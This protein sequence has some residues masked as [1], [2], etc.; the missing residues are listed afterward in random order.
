MRV[1]PSNRKSL[2]LSVVGGVIL[3]FIPVFVSLVDGRKRKVA[4]EHLK[5]EGI[6]VAFDFADSGWLRDTLGDLFGDACVHDVQRVTLDSQS[7]TDDIGN[8]LQALSP[9][10]RLVFD[11]ATI[12]PCLM[13]SIRSLEV[14]AVYFIDCK[15]DG[16][17]I[18]GVPDSTQ[19]LMVENC[20]LS[21]ISVQGISSAK[22]LEELW[23][24]RAG[25]NGGRLV[26]MRF[27]SLEI[28]SILGVPPLDAKLLKSCFPSLETL[29]V[30][31][32][33]WTEAYGKQIEN[34][35]RIQVVRSQH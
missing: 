3:L 21:G 12:G 6:E 19:F 22:S 10:K 8:A 27:P 15:F 24:D 9:I 18:F 26:G 34:A 32:E 5:S 17:V 7:V 13:S 11:G 30:S 33:L 23:L 25:V 16:R 4:C 2:K 14:E 28:L 31:E 35:L 20:D 29:F 1:A